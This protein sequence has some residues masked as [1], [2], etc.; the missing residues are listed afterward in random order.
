MARL[1]SL[2]AG[3]SLLRYVG[4]RGIGAHSFS[5]RITE[6]KDFS[7]IPMPVGSLVSFPLPSGRSS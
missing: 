6:N 3:C 4:R 5:G 7:Y 2:T 1:H